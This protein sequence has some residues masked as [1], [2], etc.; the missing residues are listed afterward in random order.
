[1][2]ER[3]V[4]AGNEHICAPCKRSRACDASIG[5]V[6]S[7]YAVNCYGELA[8]YELCVEFYD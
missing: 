6:V 1:M 3:S 7:T 4:V 5:H 8:Q 2:F